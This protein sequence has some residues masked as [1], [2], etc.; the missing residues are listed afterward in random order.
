IGSLPYAIMGAH[1]DFVFRNTV[2][3]CGLIVRL[4]LTLVL[5]SF[6]ASLVYLA[7]IQLAAMAFEYAVMWMVV[8]RR[9]PLVKLQLRDFN[10]QGVRLIFS[11]SMFVLILAVGERLMFQSDALVIGAFLDI[12]QIP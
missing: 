8:K 3:L 11:F 4:V 7:L 6:S 12:G 2:Q 1:H 9:Y 10:T 5:L